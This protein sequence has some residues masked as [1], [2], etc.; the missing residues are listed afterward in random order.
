L[1]TE[2][3]LFRT[4]PPVRYLLLLLLPLG[5]TG[6][7]TLLMLSAVLWVSIKVMPF[8]IPLILI[9]T[10]WFLKYSFVVQDRLATGTADMPVLSIEMIVGGWGEF[11]WLI[12]LFLVV[13]LFFSSGAASSHLGVWLAGSFVLVLL[14]ILPVVLVVQ[15]WTGRLANS[16][17]PAA[18]LVTIRSLGNDYAWI[19]GCAVTIVVSCVVVPAAIDQVPVFAQIALCLYAWLALIIVTGGAVH[20]NR[21]ELEARLP[22]VIPRIRGQSSEELARE[23]E[24]W[25]DTIYG[26]WRAK[27]SDNAFQTVIDRI[28]QSSDPL[29]ELR[30]LAGRVATWQPTAFADRVTAELVSRLLRE[31]FDGEALRFVLERR[32][33]V[34]DFRPLAPE[35]RERLGQLAS[36]WGDRATAEGLLRSHGLPHA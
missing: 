3:P 19:A 15:G 11:R 36:K 32:A 31:D 4:R 12:P 22:L 10:T 7:I 18:L 20:V 35:E 33:V 27:A 23:R 17:N 25:L 13:V 14:L 34:P 8:G 1:V 2:S 9:V 6:S 26:A 21:P 30:W 29:A 5:L 24:R 16:L 28:D